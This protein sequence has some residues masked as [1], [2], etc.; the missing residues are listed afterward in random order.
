MWQLPHC[1]RKYPDFSLPP[2]LSCSI[3]SL[4]LAKP[5]GSQ[6]QGSLGNVVRWDTGVL[7]AALV[8][9]EQRHCWSVCAGLRLILVC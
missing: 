2:T 3:K 4:L 8:I 7:L 9:G 6:E 5:T 1:P